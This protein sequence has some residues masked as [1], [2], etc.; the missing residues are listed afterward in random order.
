MKH[1]TPPPLSPVDRAIAAAQP[2]SVSGPTLTTFRR[3]YDD[4]VA[5]GAS[6]EPAR[7]Q[8]ARRAA[9]LHQTMPGPILIAAAGEEAP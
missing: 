6:K 3:T 4:L 8:A 7:F 5:A 9:A 2:V 1:F